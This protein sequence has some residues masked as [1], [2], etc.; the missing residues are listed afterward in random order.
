MIRC[1]ELLNQ[2]S[3]SFAAVIQA[4]HDDLRWADTTLT[5][6]SLTS[7]THFHKRREG[8]GEL[9]IQAVSRHTVQC[10]TIRLHYFVTLCITSLFE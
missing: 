1:Y 4:L 8:S 6:I 9:C 7:L 5:H 3:R 2:T 10:S